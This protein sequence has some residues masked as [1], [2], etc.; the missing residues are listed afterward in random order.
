MRAA[1]AGAMKVQAPTAWRNKDRRKACSRLLT[2]APILALIIYA[3]LAQPASAQG[4][5]DFAR[6][7]GAIEFDSGAI[8]SPAGLAFSS[9]AK[10]FLVLEKPHGRGP[11]SLGI[12]RLDDAR[13]VTGRF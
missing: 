9:T 12:K 8:E 11:R 1:L 13:G 4:R 2:L 5:P 7:V 3:F 6:A 10:E